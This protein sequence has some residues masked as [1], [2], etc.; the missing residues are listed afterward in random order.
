MSFV[1]IVSKKLYHG[2][3]WQPYPGRFT[4]NLAAD[5]IAKGRLCSTVRL[6]PTPRMFDSHELAA[7]V[8]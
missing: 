3:L 1:S 6:F 8:Q 5:C 7:I 4:T 2:F